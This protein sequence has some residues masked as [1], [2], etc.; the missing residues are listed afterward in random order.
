L[1]GK[2]MNYAKVVSLAAAILSTIVLSQTVQ[3]KDLRII[4]QLKKSAP[5]FAKKN[6]LKKIS[7]V[8]ADFSGSWVGICIGNDGEQDAAEMNISQKKCEALALDGNTLHINGLNTFANS[9]N[10]NSEWPVTLGASIATSWNDAQ[11]RLY[12]IGGF[13]LAG[14]FSGVSTGEMWL[15]GDTLRQKDTAG[16]NLDPTG[17]PSPFQLYMQDCTSTRR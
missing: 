12:T 10:P 11:T 15:E 4:E 1:K 5:T 8:C 3:A 16:Y 14:W 13:S 9:P 2:T 7:P 6:P 17:V